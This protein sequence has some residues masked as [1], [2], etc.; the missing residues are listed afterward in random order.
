M[1]S[2]SCFCFCGCSTRAASGATDAA[3]L[4]LHSG[5][6][7]ELVA[8]HCV[9]ALF[10]AVLLALL[11]ETAVAA[12]CS[13][14][15]PSALAPAIQCW[16]RAATTAWLGIVGARPGQSIPDLGVCRSATVL[17]RATGIVIAGALSAGVWMGLYFVLKR[18]MPPTV[19]RR[20]HND[21]GS[22]LASPPTT[23]RAAA[24]SGEGAARMVA[25]V[26][27]LSVCVLAAY[28]NLVAGP[29][30]YSSVGERNT[31]TQTATLQLSL[32]YFLFDIAWSVSAGGETLLL[33]CHHAAS[34]GA[35]LSGLCLD[36]SGSELVGSLFGAEISNPA[37]QLRWFLLEAGHKGSA[38]LL[39][40]DLVFA[41]TFLV[42]RVVWAPT[43]LFVVLASPKPHWCIKVGGSS[44]QL[45]SWAWSLVVVGK[46]SK[47][48]RSLAAMRGSGT[49]TDQR[50]DK[51]HS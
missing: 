20:L 9:A 37:L 24:N 34:L 28:S 33:C 41:V 47:A 23:N 39:Y 30:A 27:A 21:D 5:C 19:G 14:T 12:T 35:I 43:L 49:R 1:L 48:M 51:K 25:V 6:C 13:R 29:W 16:S 38:L 4:N 3:S 31:P 18:A 7:P 50:P 26:H 2:G 44:L 40:V 17:V 36:A 10:A 42:C 11:A 22:R 32:G 46:L 15:M 8:A 45:I